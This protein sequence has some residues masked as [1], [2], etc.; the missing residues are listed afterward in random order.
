MFLSHKKAK[1]MISARFL[2]YFSL[3][4]IILYL[5]FKYKMSVVLLYIYCYYKYM[6]TAENV[7]DSMIYFC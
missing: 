6:Y 1:F 3:Y 5:T 4:F 2:L 7:D